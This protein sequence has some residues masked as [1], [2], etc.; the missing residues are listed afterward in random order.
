TSVTFPRIDGGYYVITDGGASTL[1]RGF[2]DAAPLPE[3][4]AHYAVQASALSDKSSADAFADKLRTQ[5]GQRA[6]VIFEPG[7]GLYRVLV[8]DFPNA[9]AATALKDQLGTGT[10]IVRRP[11]DQQFIRTH[12]IADDEGQRHTIGGES[13]LI[14]PASAD[15]VTIDK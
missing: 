7:A 3:T 12:Q 2:M 10:L 8:G 11:T 13:I 5:T 9:Q 15:T 14:L 4:T 6:D 1:R